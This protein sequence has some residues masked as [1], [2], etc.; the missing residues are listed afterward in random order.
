VNDVGL[1]GQS[2][3]LVI[4]FKV[5]DSVDTFELGEISGRL[6]LVFFISLFLLGVIITKTTG[7]MNSIKN[8]FDL[9]I[10]KLSEPG[11]DKK[12][13]YKGISLSLSLSVCVCSFLLFLS[14]LFFLFSFLFLLSIYLYLFDSFSFLLSLFLSHFL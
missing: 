3:A 10:S 1:G 8:V 7:S 12:L 5:A 6:V 4:A 11:L 2:L 9:V 14:S 13:H